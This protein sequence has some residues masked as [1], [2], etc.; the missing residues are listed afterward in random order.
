M[1]D[2]HY[3]ESVSSVLDDR[4]Q[5]RPETLQAVRTFAESKPWRG[6]LSDRKQ[7]F[8]RLNDQLAAACGITRPELQFGRLDGGDSGMSFYDRPCHR[9]VL[10]GKLS[11][12]TFLHEFAHALGMGEREACRWSINLFRKCFPKQYAKLNHRR[13]MLIKQGDS[14]TGGA[15]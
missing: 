9:I 1:P 10:V 6:S 2:R 13:H 11:V 14:D 7:K 5:F 3:P 4:I 12:V 8:H 15:V